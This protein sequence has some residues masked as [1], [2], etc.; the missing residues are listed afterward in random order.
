MRQIDPNT[1]PGNQDISSLSICQV[2]RQERAA[3]GPIA[4]LILRVAQLRR[5]LK[6]LKKKKEEKVEKG[7]LLVIKLCCL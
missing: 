7:A 3:S 4:C 2:V 1:G 5:K 6:E